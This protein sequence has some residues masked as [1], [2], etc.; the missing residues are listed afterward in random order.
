MTFRSRP[1]W[2]PEEHRTTQ[3]EVFFDI[4]FIF[5]LVR[6]T[7]FMSRQPSATTLVQGLIVLLLLWISWLVYAWLGNQVRI[8]TGLARAG[9]NLAMAAVL[10]IALV[11]PDAWER[12]TQPEWGSSLTLA[13][14]YIVLRVIDLAL[15]AWAAGGVDRRLRR[16]VSIYAVSSALSWIPLV[17]GA[18]L[19]GTG[20]LLLW[21]TALAVDFGGGFLASVLS[22]WQVR[23]P[24][25]F[26]ERHSLVVIIALG[27]SLISVGLGIG[28]TKID[29]SIL[30]AALLALVITICMWR[31]YSDSADTGGRA[32]VVQSGQRRDR[33][34]A[35]AYS[36]AHFPLIA[37]IIYVAL[38]VELVLAG[39][40]H[41]GS[42]GTDDQRPGWLAMVAL[43]GGATGYLTGRAAFLRFALRTVRWRFL[44]APLL[45][46][47]LL[48]VARLLPGLAALALLAA[49][50]VGLCGFEALISRGRAPGERDQVP[51]E[52]V[53]PVRGDPQ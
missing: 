13:V 17:L 44:L 39:L 12:R 23:S 22:G 41:G 1:A 16:T 6:I 33:L 4:V 5:A 27:E 32:L 42:H 36:V 20:Q 38:G 31:L 28:A 2:N 26:A 48:P 9:T 30:A 24:S 8:G 37:G 47:A 29:L 10:V 40:T 11:L 35:N 52:R 14:A 18:V 49:F 3:Y 45:A 34:G 43:Y 19:G 15:Y 25:H 53:E 46:L 50:L 21:T 7:M 51:G